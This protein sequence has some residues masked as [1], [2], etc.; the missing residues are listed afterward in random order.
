MGCLLGA[1]GGVTTDQRALPGQH[2]VEE[3]AIWDLM[4]YARKNY[5]L[6]VTDADAK[7]VLSFCDDVYTD[8]FW[9]DAQEAWA[10]K[11]CV[12]DLIASRPW[13]WFD[14]RVVEAAQRAGTKLF[15]SAE[16]LW[17]DKMPTSL[18]TNGGERYSMLEYTI[19]DG[20]VLHDMEAF[21]LV[22]VYL[23]ITCNGSGDCRGQFYED[24]WLSYLAH[25]LFDYDLS[26]DAERLLRL[27]GFNQLH[28]QRRSLFRYDTMTSDIL[29]VFLPQMICLQELALRWWRVLNFSYKRFNRFTPGVIH[30]QLIKILDEE[31]A[32]VKIML[33][34]TKESRRITPSPT[35]SIAAM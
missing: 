25:S 1:D 32:R 28:H 35:P 12:D 8:R 14:D 31:S 30:D 9:A 11:F 16:L 26:D 27:R 7:K 13:P 15:M 33:S 20:A 4:K 29:P 23:C 3:H 18:K 19:K 17:T 6:E 2:Q 24:E 34:E 10:D 22:L 5:D 21:L